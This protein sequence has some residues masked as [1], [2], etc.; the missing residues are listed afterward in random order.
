M[1][2]YENI[3]EWYK[4]YTSRKKIDLRF[5]IESVAN[6][7]YDIYYKELENFEPDEEDNDLLRSNFLS[8]E[9]VKRIMQIISYYLYYNK[10][11][12][13]AKNKKELLF[14]IISIIYLILNINYL[15]YFQH[16]IITP[17]KIVKHMKDKMG[18]K[19]EYELTKYINEIIMKDTYI[20][21]KI[22]RKILG[23][24]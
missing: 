1:I 4:L 10:E 16:G 7:L 6:V 14:L 2:Y 12:F 18:L 17:K 5:I 24:C 3:E 19:L 9:T 22:R 8:D 11:L 21:S 20:F 13:N 23:F 15:E